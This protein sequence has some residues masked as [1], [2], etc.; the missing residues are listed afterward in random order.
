MK[1]LTQIRHERKT[2][3]HF[4]HGRNAQMQQIK[5]SKSKTFANKFNDTNLNINHSNVKFLVKLEKVRPFVKY[6]SQ[7]ATER[8]FRDP[9]GS[10]MR[11]SIKQ[12]VIETEK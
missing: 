7:S 11:P 2:Q 3:L 8:S 9:S 6:S 1:K 12:R 5:N 10:V 4:D